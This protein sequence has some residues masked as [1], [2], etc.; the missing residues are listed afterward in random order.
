MVY[1]YIPSLKAGSFKSKDGKTLFIFKYKEKKLAS[2]S[3]EGD[4]GKDLV[5]E[6]KENLLQRIKDNLKTAFK[7]HDDSSIDLEEKL[8]QDNVFFN[9]SNISFK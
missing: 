2:I 1:K 6:V 5:H 9:D 8:G 3:L 4:E 7:E